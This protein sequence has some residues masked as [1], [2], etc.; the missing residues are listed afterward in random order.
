MDKAY[1]VLTLHLHDTGARGRGGGGERPAAP[2]ADGQGGDDAGGPRRAGGA[3]RAAAREEKVALGR[4][5]RRLVTGR[6]GQVR[7]NKAP[8]G[9]GTSVRR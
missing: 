8:R 3:G 5:L 1:S 2:A 7:K 4:L 6:G 9:G